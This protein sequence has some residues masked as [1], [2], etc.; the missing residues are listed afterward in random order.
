MR[1]CYNINRN[2]VCVRKICIIYIMGV[3]EEVNARH[4]SKYRGYNIFLVAETQNLSSFPPSYFLHVAC[5]PRDCSRSEPPVST[6][7]VKAGPTDA[8]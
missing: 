1:N 6:Q 4:Y 2:T 3:K 7:S 8:V 5:A